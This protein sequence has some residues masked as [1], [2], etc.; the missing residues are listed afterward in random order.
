MN[1]TLLLAIALLSSN[2]VLS[3][4]FANEKSHWGYSGEQ[5]PEN[6]AQLTADNAACAGKN[7]S[8]VNLTGFIEAELKPLELNYL[9]GGEKILNNGHTVQVNYKKGSFVTIDGTQFKLLQFHF[10]APSENHINGKSY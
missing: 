6:W 10:H 8:P 1:K 5:G 3:N 4:A 2:I 9:Q 7:Q